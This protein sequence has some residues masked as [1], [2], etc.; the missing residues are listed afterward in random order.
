VVYFKVLPLELPVGAELGSYA[1]DTGYLHM[2]RRARANGTPFLETLLH[3]D[4]MDASRG[5]IDEAGAREN[6]LTVSLIED[7]FESVRERE[8]ADRPS[9]LGTV[10]VF[11]TLPAAHEFARTYR[12]TVSCWIVDL[13]VETGPSFET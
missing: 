4:W 8:F 13:E 3:A 10:H 9:R 2:V 5:R 6:R 11:K 12:P 7:V 1:P